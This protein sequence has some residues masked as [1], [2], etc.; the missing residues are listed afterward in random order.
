[1]TDRQMGEVCLSL[2]RRGVAHCFHPALVIEPMHS[3]EGCKLDSRTGFPWSQAVNQI[4]LVES[5]D[6]FGLGVVVTVASTADRWFDPCLGQSLGVA[7]ADVLGSALRV[8]N[9]QLAAGLSV[10]A[11]LLRG[12]PNKARLHGSAAPPAHDPTPVDVDVESNKEPAPPRPYV[13][14]IRYAK[15][16]GPV[17]FGIPVDSVN[18]ARRVHD[19]QGHSSTLAAPGPLQAHRSHPPPDR[20]AGHSNALAIHL[21][22]DLTSSVDLHAGVTDESDLRHRLGIAL[23]TSPDQCR[24]TL[25]GSVSAVC[26][27]GKPQH[28]ADRLN[29]NSATALI[30]KRFDHF[31]G[32]SS[33]AWAKN[34]LARFRISLA[35]RSS[36]TSC[37][38]SLNF[39]LST[40][41]MPSR[42][43]IA[44]SSRRIHSYRA[45]GL[46][47]MLDAMDSVVA[48]SVGTSRGLL[49]ACE[50]HDR[51]PRIKPV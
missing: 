20:V 23:R 2:C 38:G 1:M 34:A 9:E 44:T 6:G 45:W 7:D 37:S 26:R 40:V 14:E 31:I 42:A 30:D 13:G 27:W 19:R 22:P 35:R 24:V 4:C 10:V 28:F 47:R 21:L 3:V 16:I 33:S 8:V 46:Q 49:A 25:R 17:G 41:V 11:R 39:S 48:H 32:R 5:V 15:L 51:R 12:L 43:P 18:R 29:T 50:R 36:L